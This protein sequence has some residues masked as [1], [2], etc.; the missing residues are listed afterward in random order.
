MD[1]EPARA[2]HSAESQEDNG[3][4]SDASEYSLAHAAL[5]L[6]IEDNVRLRKRH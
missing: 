3:D 4:I 6:T 5:G 1:W 2:V